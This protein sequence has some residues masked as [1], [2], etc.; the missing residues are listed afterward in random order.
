MNREKLKTL[1]TYLLAERGEK[2]ELSR[3]GSD[4]ELFRL[5]RSLVNI[6]PAAPAE[7]SYLLTED[8]FLTELTEEKGITDAAALVPAEKNIYLWKGDITTLRCGAIVNAANSEMTGCYRPCHSC[9]DN[10]IHTF[11]GIRLRYECDRI[12]RGQKHNEPAGQAKLTPAYDLPADHVI[13]TVGPIVNGE[14]TDEHRR[15]LAG[16]YRSCLETAAENGIESIAFCC[17]STGVFGYPHYEAAVTAV[18]TVREYLKSH[19][20]KVIFN[21]FTD[22][23]HKI[24]AGL[25]GQ[26]I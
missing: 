4:A 2:Q 23:D 11:A 10:C 13:H 15:L 9:I 6:R 24:Y 17:I 21:V 16:C 22:E 12:I 18:G 7:E 5:Y 14:L 1:I 20:I 25:L 19:D 26:R 8:S 3:I